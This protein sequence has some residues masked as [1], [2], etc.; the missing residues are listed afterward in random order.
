MY[1]LNWKPEDRRPLE[2]P[3]TDGRKILNKYGVRGSGLNW[4]RRASSGRQF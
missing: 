1:N 4:V 2:D 3:G